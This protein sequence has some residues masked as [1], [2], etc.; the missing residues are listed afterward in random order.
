MTKVATLPSY[1][2][3][4][5]K[6]IPCPIKD[7]DCPPYCFPKKYLMIS[8]CFKGYSKKVGN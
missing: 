1:E 5:A 7:K 2:A 8:N 4:I 3:I 6:I